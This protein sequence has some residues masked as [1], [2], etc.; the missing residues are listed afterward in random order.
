MSGSSSIALL[1]SALSELFVQ[2]SESG[3]LTLA[4]RYGMMAAL[5]DGSLT[6]DE[7]QVLDRVLRSLQRGRIQV[8]DELSALGITE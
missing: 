6:A 5:L 7:L 2:V 3:K 8:V 1:P 4:D